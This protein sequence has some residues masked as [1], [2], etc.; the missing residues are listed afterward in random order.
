MQRPCVAADD[1]C[2]ASQKRHQLAESAA[3]DEGV[4]VTTCAEQGCGYNVIIRSG[5]NDATQSYRFSEP[6]AQG[7]EALG[8]PALGAPATAGAQDNIMIEALFTQTGTD[9]HLILLG[10]L[11]A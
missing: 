10:N 8:R 5:I 4:R 1:A 2:S 9:G 3:K 6:A 7:C 11:Q